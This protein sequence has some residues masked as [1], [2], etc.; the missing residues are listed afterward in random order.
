M[1]NARRWQLARI[2]V[3]ILAGAGGL[4]GVPGCS[5]GPKVEDLDPAS[6]VNNGRADVRKR[7]AAVDRLNE[8]ITDRGL[9]REQLKTI[10]WQVGHPVQ[11]RQRAVEL[12]LADPNDPQ[13]ADTRNMVRLMLPVEPNVAMVGV[14]SGIAAE[15]G[16]TDAS[17]PLIRSWSRVMGGGQDVDRPERAA[18]VKLHAPKPLDRVLFETFATPATGEGR[19]REREERTR[20][21]AWALLSREDADGSRRRDWLAELPASDDPLIADLRAS[22]DQ[23]R[24]IPVT[25]SQLE[26]VKRLRD[27]DAA[28]DPSLAKNWWV[29]SSAALAKLQGEQVKGLAIRHAEPVRWASL[30]RSAWL[31]MD[32]DGLLSELRQRMRGRTFYGRGGGEADRLAAVEGKLVWAD[33]LALLVIDESLRTPGLTDTL[34]AQSE[35]DRQDTS[36][37]YGGL[38]AARAAAE[39]FVAAVYPPRPTQRYGDT[40][41]VASDDLVRDGARSLVHYHFHSQK[42]DNREYAGPGPGD[43]EY[44]REHGALC[45]V[46]TPVGPGRLDATYFHAGG[47]TIDLG[48][49][50]SKSAA[51][52]KSAE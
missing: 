11:V 31:A 29:Q 33:L 50:V 43:A 52:A 21:A 16:W 5:S 18:L 37:E 49:L 24:A 4:V 38:I 22:A 26:W 3:L 2:V 32:R 40:R 15:R 35:R 14:L 1:S 46:F 44:A 45:V 41:F 23:L 8:S 48:E 25:A 12:L 51:E 39:G 17:G 34:W 42:L 30:Y 20:T 27:T 7:V 36:T 13:Q 28:T 47:I 6:V 19:E 10:A 9:A